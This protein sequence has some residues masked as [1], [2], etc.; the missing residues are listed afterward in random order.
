MRLA[1]FRPA[2]RGLA[3]LTPTLALMLLLGMPLSLGCETDTSPGEPHDNPPPP[4]SRTPTGLRHAPNTG[5]YPMSN[6]LS[7]EEAA[8]LGA[9]TAEGETEQ[10]DSAEEGPETTP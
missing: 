8:A 9:S 6:E 1:S 5:A 3:L 7:E 10:E 2:T 4:P